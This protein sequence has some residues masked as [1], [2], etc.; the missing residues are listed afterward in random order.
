MSV[1]EE[2][3]PVVLTTD[4]T[5][6]KLVA[7]DVGTVVHVYRDGKAYQ[8]EFVSLSG[9]IVAVV[10]IERSQLRPVVCREITH[11]RRVA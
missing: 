5:A 3:D 4:L 1:I 8:V 7:G 9:E 11:A 10:T 6:E 2:H